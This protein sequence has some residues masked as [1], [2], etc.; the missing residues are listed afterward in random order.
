[1]SMAIKLKRYLLTPFNPKKDCMTNSFKEI[2]EVNPE[3]NDFSW[4]SCRS[5][6]IIRV[7]TCTSCKRYRGNIYDKRTRSHNYKE[8]KK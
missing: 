3:N 8:K 5:Q 7:R 2:V 1:M 6:G 4:M